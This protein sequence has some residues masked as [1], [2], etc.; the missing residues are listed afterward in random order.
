MIRA[1]IIGC[2]KI[3][4][5]WD[6]LKDD[7][8]NTHAKSYY[9][10]KD[11]KLVACADISLKKAKGLAKRYRG[12][13]PYVDY[14]EMLSREDLD[15]VSVCTPCDT[16]YKVLKYILQHTSVKYI[17][18]EKPLVSTM[19]EL[20][21]IIKIAKKKRACI[22]INYLRRFDNGFKKVKSIVENKMGKFLFGFGVYYGR[23]RDNGIHLID[24]IDFWGIKVIFKSRLKNGFILSSTT[25]GE[26]IFK[27]KEKES[28]AALELELFFEKGKVYM[29]DTS[30]IIIFYPA[31]LKEIPGYKVL[32]QRIVI[33]PTIRKSL[34]NVVVYTVGLVKH[35]KLTYEFLER[36]KNLQRIKEAIEK[37]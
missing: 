20:Q 31:V 37:K 29:H 36:E 2:G 19:W 5:E 23:F 4:W 9:F 26:L 22:I 25:G 15:V 18:A 8:F 11:V 3:A 12:V 35:K 21:E 14:E 30:E 1:G 27:N 17:L 32:T 24:L 6:N 7:N 34:Y 13:I 33:P 28:Y 16:H 10:N